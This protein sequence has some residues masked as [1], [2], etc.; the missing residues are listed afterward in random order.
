MWNIL[1]PSVPCNIPYIFIC[2]RFTQKTLFH[3]NKSLSY[4]V[5]FVCLLWVF[6]LHLG[7]RQQLN[8]RHATVCFSKSTRLVLW[9]KP[10]KRKY[11]HPLKWIIHTDTTLHMKCSVLLI[12]FSIICLCPGVIWLGKAAGVWWWVT[13]A[14]RRR[15]LLLPTLWWVLGQ[16]R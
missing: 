6:V 11:L 8:V 12:H 2:F 4:F 5:L 13:V 15:I 3:C 14:E 9:Q 1:L 7:W 10:L 16:D